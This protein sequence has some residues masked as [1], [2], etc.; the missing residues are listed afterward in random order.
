MTTNPQQ[1]PTQA[2]SVGAPKKS[3]QW[4]PVAVI[5][6]AT[7]ALIAGAAILLVSHGG[8]AEWSDQRVADAINKSLNSDPNS[9]PG[10][11]P[12]PQYRASDIPALLATYCPVLNDEQA[13]VAKA[14]APDGDVEPGSA[15][16]EKSLWRVV[17][18]QSTLQ[19]SGRC[20]GTRS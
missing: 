3:S 1:E 18:I 4:V 9:T 8:S 12:P 19:T 20:Q 6:T 11:A 15:Q 5:L 13:M 16:W 17:S 14:A 7:A 10:S 2:E